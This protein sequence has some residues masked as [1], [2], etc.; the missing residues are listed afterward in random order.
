MVI[1]AA[2]GVILVG[3]LTIR[4]ATAGLLRVARSQLNHVLA[5]IEA[6]RSVMETIT[7]VNTTMKQDVEKTIK[8][9]ETRLENQTNVVK[10]LTQKMQDPKWMDDFDRGRD[11]SRWN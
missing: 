10:L 8:G 7:K 6:E 11:N 2:V 1:E 3:Y 5:R 9:Y 4:L